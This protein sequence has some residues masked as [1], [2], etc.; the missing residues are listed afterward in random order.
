MLGITKDGNDDTNTSLL[1]QIEMVDL[2][3]QIEQSHSAY[4]GLERRAAG[5]VRR[6]SQSAADR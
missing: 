2:K 5:S 4:C 6:G 3:R 1:Q